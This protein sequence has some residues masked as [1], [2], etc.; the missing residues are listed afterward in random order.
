MGKRPTMTDIANAAGVSQATVSLVLSGAAN[1]RVSEETR[2]RVA[3]VAAEMGYA[4]RGGI[5]RASG[6]PVLGL[7]I[8]EVNTTPF[9]MPFLEAARDEA[10]GIG[11]IVASFVTN[12]DPATE[13]AALD[14]LQAHDLK[15]VL[16]IT[17]MTRSVRVP[18]RLAG[19]PAVLVNCHE[20]GRRIPTILP[21]DVAGGQAAT[22]CLIRAGHRRIAHIPG[23]SWG[24]AARDRARGWRQALAGHDIPVD[25]ALLGAPAWT[26][27]SGRDAMAAL[28]ALPEPPT[29]VFCFNDRVAMGACEAIRARG[30]RVP[31]D[32]SI[33]GFDNED[34]VAYLDPGLTTIQLPHEEMARTA[35]GLILD[36]DGSPLP[37]RRIKVDCPPVVRASV[38]S[39]RV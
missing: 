28:L 39:P 37:F 26:V 30:L 38:A 10:A 13:A 6:A 24:E 5:P 7:L 21:G 31:D 16:Y 12:R 4:R 23:E 11:W 22:E 17:L 20:I 34:V 8:D 19:I 14:L 15:G 35:V 3:Q 9:A 1:V 2:A 36:A 25:P 33:C 27:G 18:D 29:A 32:I